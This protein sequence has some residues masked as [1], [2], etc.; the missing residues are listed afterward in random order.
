MYGPLTTDEI[1]GSP[2]WNS[3]TLYEYQF[4]TSTL[5]WPYGRY[6]TKSSVVH[7]VENKGTNHQGICQGNEISLY[8]QDGKSGS[9]WYVYRG[10]E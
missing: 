9:Y 6:R 4:N 10:I 5:S 7:K 8:P 2:T 1:S 3:K